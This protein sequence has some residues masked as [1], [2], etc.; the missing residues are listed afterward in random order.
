MFLSE[1]CQDQYLGHDAP[2]PGW[3]QDSTKAGKYCLNFLLILDNI[4]QEHV[5]CVF[6]Q[7]YY[8]GHVAPNPGWNHD[9]PNAGKYC[10]FF[11]NSWAHWPGACN[12]FFSWK[13][14][15]ISI[16]NMLLPMLDETRI[17]TNIS[18]HMFLCQNPLICKLDVLI[19]CICS[20]Y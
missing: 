13:T 6:L 14:V 10:L 19:S 4:D 5:T 15:K 18:L 12:L 16:L 9:F 2:N 1:N 7:N 17:R 20:F 11:T 3:N 8:L